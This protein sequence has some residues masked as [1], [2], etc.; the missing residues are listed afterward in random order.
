MGRMTFAQEQKIGQWL[1][2]V[3][4][5]TLGI[6]MSLIDSNPWWGLGL[7]VAL[8]SPFVWARILRD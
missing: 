1:I 2:V 5:T 7:Y 3:F 4:A 6:T 8:V